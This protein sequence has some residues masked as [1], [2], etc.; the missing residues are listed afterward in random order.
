VWGGIAGAFV[1]RLYHEPQVL[2]L[3]LAITLAMVLDLL[4]GR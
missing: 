3:G 4:M 2:M 1:W